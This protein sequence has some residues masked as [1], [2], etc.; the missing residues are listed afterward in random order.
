[1]NWMQKLY[2]TYEICRHIPEFVEPPQRE[3]GAEA[4]GLM[5]VSHV[6]RQAHICVTLDDRG[7]FLDAELLPSKQQIVIPATEDSAARTSDETPHPLADKIQYC[8]KDDYRSD[9]KQLY[10]LYEKLLKAWCG[11]PHGHPMA[12]AVYAYVSGGTLVRDLL[13]K[14]ILHADASGAWLTQAPSNE[15]DSIFKRLTAKNAVRDQAEAMVVWKVQLTDDPEPR[16]WKNKGLQASWVAYDAELMQSKALCMVNGTENSIGTKHPRDIRRIGDSAKL[17]TSNDKKGFTFRG[18]FITPE[19]ACT[20]GYEVSQKAHNALRWLIARQGY[21]NGDQA[22]VAWAVKRVDVPNPGVWRPQDEEDFYADDEQDAPSTEGQEPTVVVHRDMGQAFSRRLAK[23]MR[24]YKAKL[25]DADGIAVL[26]LDAAGPGRLSVSFYREQ[27]A[28]EYLNRL[29]EWQEDTA[30]VLPV[31]MREARNAGSEFR[32]VFTPCA[33]L[34]EEIAR[35][36]YGRRIDEKLL[37]ATV[38]RLL[39]CIVDGA[40]IPLDLVESCVRRACNRVGLET[41][42]WPLVS[43]TA[44]ALYKGFYARHPQ[45][46]KRRNYSMTLERDRDSRDY[47]YGRLLA[48]A[49]YAER[50][51]LDQAGEKR[52]TNAERLMQRFADNPCATWLI[53]QKQLAPYMQRIQSYAPPLHTKIK[54]ALQEICDKYTSVDDFMS[55]RRLSGEFLLGYHCQLSD[56]YRK[57]DATTPTQE[58]EEE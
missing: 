38:E 23:V 17:I 45:P 39:P 37:K 20:V 10:D 24:G 57:K 3:D 15:Q 34:P 6:S 4:V 9:K 26:A 36:A 48:V 11:S 42:E 27:T 51:A 12:R 46:E 14:G 44:C 28:D 43:A 47:L 53:L 54:K 32:T 58:G 19:E 2:A 50:S 31:K 56:L 18:R 29:Q 21:R 41:W 22:V 5:P 25:E 52:P 35:V 16:A 49:E 33:P 30:W 40:S 7:N 8:A 55:P 1:M 13:R